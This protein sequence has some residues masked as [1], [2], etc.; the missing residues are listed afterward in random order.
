MVFWYLF[1]NV[2][3]WDTSAQ[4]NDPS[5]PHAK[6]NIQIFLFGAI[7]YIFTAGFLWSP[8]YTPL[9]NSIFF[10]QVL[11][12]FFSWFVFVDVI[13]CFALFKKFW[14]HGLLVEFEG[15]MESKKTLSHYPPTTIPS[16]DSHNTITSDI[17]TLSES[18]SEDDSKE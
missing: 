8:L 14:G 17:D 2:I 16:S 11:R 7:S 10:L 3:H 9:V 4:E 6:K 1:S 18:N 5:Y 13:V 15:I 12:D